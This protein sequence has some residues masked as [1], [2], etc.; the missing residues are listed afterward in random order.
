MHGLLAYE[1][2]SN[3]WQRNPHVRRTPELGRLLYSIPIIQIFDQDK[4]LM[5]IAVR[6]KECLVSNQ[7]LEGIA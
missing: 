3:K 6:F 1:T 5:T 7:P 2:L 4:V